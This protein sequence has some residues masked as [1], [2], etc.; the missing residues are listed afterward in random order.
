MTEIVKIILL[1]DITF[2]LQNVQ[3]NFA[4]EYS[5]VIAKIKFLK[6]LHKKRLYYLHHTDSLKVEFKA[7]RNGLIPVANLM[8]NLW[9]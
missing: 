7:H 9:S 4:S 3:Q 5:D 6:Y 2:L 1:F 8:S